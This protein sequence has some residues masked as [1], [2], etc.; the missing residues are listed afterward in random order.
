MLGLDD[1]VT[2]ALTGFRMRVAIA[3][4]ADRTTLE[5]IVRWADEH[6]PVACTLRAA[7]PIAVSVE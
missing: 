2:P 1:E 6:S 5:D 3:G 7:L 4:D